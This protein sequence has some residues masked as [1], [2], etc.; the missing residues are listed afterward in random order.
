MANSETRGPIE[1]VGKLLIVAGVAVWIPFTVHLMTGHAP[2]VH[3]YL[4]FHLSGVIP[5]AILLRR[6]W[7]QRQL[8]RIRR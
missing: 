8:R 2:D 5:G 6:R 7:L 4:P 1:W 3:G